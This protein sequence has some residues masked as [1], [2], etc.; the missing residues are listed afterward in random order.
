MQG[1]E[2]SEKFFFQY[3][4]P[5][6]E[7]N[8]PEVFPRLAFGLAGRGSECFGFD[9][10][11]SRDHDFNTGFLI[12]LNKQDDDLWGFELARAYSAL[13]R[14]YKQ[15]NN[16]EN[17]QLGE[18]E[19][20]VC[21]IADFY[22]RRIGLPGIPSCWQEWLYTPEYAFAEAVNGKVFLDN[23]G[24]FSAI[25]Q[26]LFQGMPED[27]RLKKTAAR[28]ALLA[29][30]GQYNYQRCLRHQEPGAAALALGEFVRNCGSL[31]FLFNHAFCPY[32]KWMFRA[33]KAL[34]HLG[35]LAFPLEFLLTDP[36]KPE[37]KQALIED[38][39]T[40]I[41]GELKNQQL[42]DINDPYLEAHAF[43]VMKKIQNPQIRSL[44]V[45]E[46]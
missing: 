33:M 6:F 29:Q 37:E 46:G 12:W 38:I 10:P 22:E 1:L 25:R 5:L 8:F 23:S 17:S 3:G 39:C 7:K 42:S 41:I 30:S 43:A 44:H 16:S 11:V 27:V 19:Q 14:E 45:M 24:E 28:L 13:C 2:Q 18:V 32:Y 21:C 31:I 15:Q 35:E 40:Q 26:T 34:P 36:G 4:L 9:D 20:G